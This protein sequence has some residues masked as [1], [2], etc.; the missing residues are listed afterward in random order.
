MMGDDDDKISSVDLGFLA[1]KSEG[2]LSISNP[3][4]RR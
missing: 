3:H 4:F 1:I 2:D